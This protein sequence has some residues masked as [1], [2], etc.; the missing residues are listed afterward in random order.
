MLI[1][2]ALLAYVV[3]LFE[4]KASDMHDEDVAPAPAVGPQQGPEELVGP[5]IMLVPGARYFGKVVLTGITSLLANA[6]AVKGKLGELG[7]NPASVW[8]RDPPPF[9]PDAHVDVPGST[10][11][12]AG[13]YGGKLQ[14]PKRPEVLKRVWT[15]PPAEI[16]QLPA[17]AGDL[18]HPP[19]PAEAQ[20]LLVHLMSEEGRQA[21]LVALQAE[22]W[23]IRK[24]IEG[25][26]GWDAEAEA[27][28]TTDPERGEPPVPHAPRRRKPPRTR[29]VRPL[30]TG[31]RGELVEPE[32][33]DA[34]VEMGGG[35]GQNGLST[36]EEVLGVLGL[37]AAGDPVSGKEVP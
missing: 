22:G 8:T 37:D 20:E 16:P 10:Y 17:A 26:M 3:A 2:F 25:L 1:L 31:P 28:A 15:V 23:R 35:S 6:S 5:T 27:P 32:A 14:R 13:V 30:V 29:H 21:Q 34:G 7:F 12:I 11:F 19:L 4:R 18:A 9:F 36:H 24:A 33:E